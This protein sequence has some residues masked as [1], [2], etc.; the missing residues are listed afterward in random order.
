M[1]YVFQFSDCKVLLCDFHREQAWGRWTA[2][3]DNGVAENRECIL[4]LMRQL[5]QA[6]TEDA[7]ENALKQLRDTHEWKTNKNF[8]KW[9]ENTWLRHKK[10]KRNSRFNQCNCVPSEC[11]A[12]L[13]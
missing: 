2:K 4:A 1:D 6:R 10:V 11:T 7:Y 5:A 13:L 9:L 3:K 12:V 8:K